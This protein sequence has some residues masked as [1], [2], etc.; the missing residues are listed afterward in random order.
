MRCS[1]GRSTAPACWRS[2]SP[3]P[4]RTTP[5]PRSSRI[6]EAEQSRK[7]AGQRLADRIAKPLVPG[8]MIARRGHRRRRSARS[9]T[10]VTWIERALVVLVAAS[11]CALAISVPVT[12]VAAIGAASKHGAL[13]KGGAAL[14]ALGACQDR[15]AGQDRHPDPQPPAV[16]E[17]PS[18]PG[19]TA[20]T[21]PRGGRGAGS[22]QRT[23]LGAPRSWPPPPT[24]DAG[25]GRRSGHRCRAHRHPGRARRPAGPSGLDRRR[26]AG[27]GRGAD[28]ARRSHR[29]ARRGR[30]RPARR[31][32]GP[33]RAAPRSARGR[34]RPCAA[35]ATGWPCSPATTTP[36]PP[37]WPPRPGI[38]R[39]HAELRPEDK[40]RIVG[41]LRAHGPV[42]MVGDGVNDAPALATADLGIA[43]GAMGT[44]VAIETA[45]V[46]LMGE[47]LRHLPHV[48]A[49]ARRSRVIMLQN[50]GL[51]LG[52]HYRSDAPGPVR[53]PRPGRGRA[54]ARGRRGR[55]H[56]QRHPR[57]TH[58]GAA[59]R[60]GPITA[61]ARTRS[62]Q[63]VR[64]GN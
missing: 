43:M 5:W 53:H 54:G 4:P 12:V 55:G 8:V 49:H 9:A 35:P 3:P 37:P 47:D 11:P 61:G 15:G 2:R 19:H 41:Q 59:D 57:R 34:R 42:A 44:D 51:S 20:R 62:R 48:L 46:A 45:D 25:C 14:E 33:R 31:H 56:R 13:V 52:H 30:R 16:I 10:R 39:V 17:S 24:P 7:G 18:R 58:P 6:V 23:P 29:R 50:V 27:R 64:T 22:A 28:A 26:S 32:R 63:V 40:A 38:D 21:G 36:P 1:P 60:S